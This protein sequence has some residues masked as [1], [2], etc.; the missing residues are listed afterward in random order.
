MKDEL[1]LYEINEG[2]A[3][4]TLNRPDSLNAVTQE[5]TGKLKETLDIACKDNAVKVIVL[6]GAGRGFCAGA[7]MQGLSAVTKGESR[8]TYTPEKRDYESN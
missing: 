5:M 6:T 4:V 7:D 3:K 2:V 1:V 8:S